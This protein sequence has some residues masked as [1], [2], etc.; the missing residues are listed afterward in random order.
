MIKKKEKSK[1]REE[2]MNDSMRKTEANHFTDKDISKDSDSDSS[3]DS[4]SSDD[5]VCVKKPKKL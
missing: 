5:I 4:D 1:Q 2:D 3:K